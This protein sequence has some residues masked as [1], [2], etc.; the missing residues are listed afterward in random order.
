MT[1][2]SIAD[3][4]SRSNRNYQWTTDDME[5]DVGHGEHSVRP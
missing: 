4:R 2:S 1:K 3:G 5:R